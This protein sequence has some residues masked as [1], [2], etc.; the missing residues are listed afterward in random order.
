MSLQS[1]WSKTTVP[2]TN[3]TTSSLPLLKC[4]HAHGKMC[5]WQSLT[6]VFPSLLFHLQV[7]PN[8]PR[9][10]QTVW[11]IPSLCSGHLLLFYY[12]MILCI[13][14][15]LVWSIA[16][17]FERGT[18]TKIRRFDLPP[19]YICCLELCCSYLSSNAPKQHLQNQGE[20][21]TKL[22]L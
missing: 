7:T 18:S 2:C 17:S 22:C 10:L 4:I 21:H 8:I 9:F 6:F 3:C 1:E 11:P 16:S 12:F 19:L 20:K 15:L 13:F 14:P 5:Y